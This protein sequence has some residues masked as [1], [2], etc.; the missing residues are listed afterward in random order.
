MSN[1]TRNDANTILLRLKSWLLIA[2]QIREFCYSCNKFDFLHSPSH[3]LKPSLSVL[4][5][6]KVDVKKKRRPLPK[7]FLVLSF[8]GVIFCELIFALDISSIQIQL[9]GVK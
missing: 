7:L 3:L 6:K 1:Y 5:T 4:E 9:K 2:N 8:L